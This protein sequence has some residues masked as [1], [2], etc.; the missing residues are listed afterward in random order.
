MNTKLL[1]THRV[2]KRRW[3]TTAGNKARWP[4][5]I[6]DSMVYGKCRPAGLKDF[7]AYTHL[8]RAK[9]RVSG[10]KTTN[11]H[12]TT[13]VKTTTSPKRSPPKTIQ[14]IIQQSLNQKALGPKKLFSAF[15]SKPKLPQ[16]TKQLNKD[17]KTQRQQ[18]TKPS[19]KMS[20]K[21]KPKLDLTKIQFECDTSISLSSYTDQYEKT[22]SPDKPAAKRIDIKATPEEKTPEIRRS[23]RQRKGT[24]ATTLGNA[25]PIAQ[26]SNAS[27]SCLVAHVELATTDISTPDQPAE[28]PQVDTNRIPDS[29]PSQIS[30][31]EII[32]T[33]I[34][35]EAATP[36]NKRYET[37]SDSTTRI[38]PSSRYILEKAQTTEE[39]FSK[40]FEEAMNILH[41]ISPVRGV[42]MTFQRERE[43]TTEQHEQVGA[44]RY[45]R[46][47]THKK[48][49]P[50]KPLK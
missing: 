45:K 28:I 49:M 34:H 27:E 21:K 20:P 11:Q 26:I 19:G 41:S 31:E 14:D 7:V 12:T 16:C 47:R 4:T 50:Q 13:E 5:F 8:P 44:L 15:N 9:P 2:D 3:Q 18:Q 39:S 32:C 23:S 22:P 33:E 46:R 29:A 17:P 48:K 38:K 37:T 42:S 40:N 43:Y 24:L 6:P 10:K 25:I 1:P 36:E 30:C 35:M